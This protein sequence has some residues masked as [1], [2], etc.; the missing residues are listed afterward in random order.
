MIFCRLV[1]QFTDCNN[2]STAG[3][4]MFMIITR[5][6]CRILNH[7]NSVLLYSFDLIAICAI[8]MSFNTL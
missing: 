3:M 5:F 4:F 1:H 6:V 2:L 7:N 8:E